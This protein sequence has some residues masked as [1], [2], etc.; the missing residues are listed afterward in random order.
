MDI[1]QS[2]KFALIASFLFLFR[3]PIPDGTR[4]MELRAEQTAREIEQV[5]FIFWNIYLLLFFT[6][7]PSPLI[8]QIDALLICY[9]YFPHSHVDIAAA[10]KLIVDAPRKKPLHLS[11]D[12]RRQLKHHGLVSLLTE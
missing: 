4:E 5:L 8:H 3:M 12:Q 7:K 11:L 2:V 10:K 9:F 6:G 1:I